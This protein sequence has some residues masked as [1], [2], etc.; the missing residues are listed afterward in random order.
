MTAPPP[1]PHPRA[2]TKMPILNRVNFNVFKVDK[3]EMLKLM[4]CVKI[5]RTSSFSGPYF[6]TFGLNTKRY[7]RVPHLLF[8]PIR[9][10]LQKCFRFKMKTQLILFHLLSLRIL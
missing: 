4:H 3:N 7:E 5:A 2:A 6:P 1:P 8:L 9:P 10:Q